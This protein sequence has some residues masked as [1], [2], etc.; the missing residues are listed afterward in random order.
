MVMGVAE[1]GV[2]TTDAVASWLHKDVRL[3]D[4]F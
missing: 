2:M 1:Y 3:V 4:V